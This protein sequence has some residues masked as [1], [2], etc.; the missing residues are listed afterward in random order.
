[1]NGCELPVVINSGSGNQGMTVSIP[2]VTYAEELGSSEEKLYRALVIS[3]LVAIH[4]K[5][6]IGALSAYCGAT[7]AGAGAGA[8]VCYLYGGNQEQIAHTIVNTLAINSGMIC[9][10]AKS[11]CAAKIA[12]A[13]EAGLLGMQMNMYDNQFYGGDGIVIKG[14]ENTIKAVGELAREGMR[15]TDDKIID[16]MMK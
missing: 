15:G 8:G 12:S 1:M 2:V 16:I 14:V 9:D 13:V 4:I 3:N 6:G 7:S 5:T 11:S 10:G